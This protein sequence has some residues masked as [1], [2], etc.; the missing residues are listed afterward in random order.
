MKKRYLGDVEDC[1]SNLKIHSDPKYYF[2]DLRHALT[3]AQMSNLVQLRA[4]RAVSRGIFGSVSEYLSSGPPDRV[5]RVIR[6]HSS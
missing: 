6:Y 2:N 3:R 4:E 5:A 1:L